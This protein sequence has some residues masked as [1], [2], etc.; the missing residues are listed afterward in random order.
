MAVFWI[1]AVFAASALV[2]LIA[3]RVRERPEGGANLGEV[4][5]QWLAEQ[6]MGRSDRMR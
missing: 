5:H 3:R 1:L 6:R 4:S 2:Y